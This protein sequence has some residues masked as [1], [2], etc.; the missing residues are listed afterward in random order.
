MHQTAAL[1][2]P[3]V[4]SNN[5]GSSSQDSSKPAGKLKNIIVPLTHQLKTSP[6]R[7]TCWTLVAP[8]RN[9]ATSMT[10]IDH[11]IK[12]HLDVLLR[13]HLT[14][15]TQVQESLRNSKAT[16]V[17][18][19]SAK[20]IRYGCWLGPKRA[21]AAFLEASAED[22]AAYLAADPQ[23]PFVCRTTLDMAEW[24]F[25]LDRKEAVNKADWHAVSGV[26]GRGNFFVPRKAREGS[27]LAAPPRLMAF[28]EAFRTINRG[29]WS[30]VRDTLG[31]VAAWREVESKAYRERR[32]AALLMGMAQ[33]ITQG[34]HFGV[35]EAQVGSGGDA[36]RLRSHK[37][38]ATS[39]LHLGLTLGGR[40]IVRMGLFHSPH[41]EG[42]LPL[43]ALQVNLGAN[44]QGACKIQN[45]FEQDVWNTSVWD[46]ENLLDVPMMSG[47]AYLSSPFCFEHAVKHEASDGHE[48][49]MA[50]QFRWALSGELGK[51]VNQLRTEDLG[52]VAHIIAS[53]LSTCATQ[54]LLRVPSVE[55]VQVIEASRH[56]A[57]ELSRCA[58]VN[59]LCQ[60]VSENAK[61]KRKND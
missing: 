61:N 45:L 37:D 4:A 14:Q 33:S 36:R 49:V 34:W 32:S 9:V 43:K 11:I 10:G 52:D 35:V 39:L 50:L 13:E 15:R 31:H 21:P 1:R 20:P 56:T 2:Q 3:G 60:A 23:G 17:H 18:L 27:L 24:E 40:R 58:G 38:G 28:A 46:K 26:G 55:E 48:N 47:A 19:D 6:Y 5:A 51:Q 29:C 42:N 30:T 44:R 22:L 53:V 25:H 16:F 59:R 12:H 54:G 7:Q 57:I 8:V 41:S